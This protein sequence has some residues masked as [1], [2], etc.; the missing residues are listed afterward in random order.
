MAMFFYILLVI[1]TIPKCN[2]DFD[3]VLPEVCQTGGGQNSRLN[4]TWIESMVRLAIRDEQGHHA[5]HIWGPTGKFM[6]SK[7]SIRNY[8]IQL[9]ICTFIDLSTVTFP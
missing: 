8:K 3:V 7:Y 9:I 4:L 6:I 2:S 5:L 1:V